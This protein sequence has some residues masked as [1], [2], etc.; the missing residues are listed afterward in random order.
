L[1]RRVERFQVEH[2]DLVERRF[3]DPLDERCEREI[4]PGAP[5]LVEERR[6][7]D[8]FATLNRIG[9]DARKTQQARHCGPDSFAQ[10]AAIQTLLGRR[11]C[12]RL[13]HGQRAAGFAARRVDR[14]IDGIPEA[15]NASAV[16]VP[17]GEPFAPGLGRLRSGISG[18]DALAGSRVGVDPRREVLRLQRR[19]AQQ[20]VA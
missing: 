2:A 17:V 15:G 5:G 18:V 12:K 3:L 14:D 19:K 1:L 6:Q 20:Q 11:S 10:G 13:Q 8:V 4:A 9:F 7:Q 16:L